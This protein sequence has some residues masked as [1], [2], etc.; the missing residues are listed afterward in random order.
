MLAQTHCILHSHIELIASV[1][2]FY[3]FGIIWWNLSWYVT[4][5][6]VFYAIWFQST[7]FLT[8]CLW[9]G[10]EQCD[11]QDSNWNTW[12]K[13]TPSLK[14]VITTVCP[15][16]TAESVAARFLLMCLFPYYPN[17]SLS[18]SHLALFPTMLCVFY[19]FAM[20]VHSHGRVD[21]ACL[22]FPV[23]E[24]SLVCLLVC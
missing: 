17:L 6:G 11:S 4:L 8:L 7:E 22:A 13:Y 14:V 16:Y 3:H 5:S 12:H 20:V 21:L 15:V 18:N 19:C 1:T 2:A 9:S 24:I 10:Y 23:S